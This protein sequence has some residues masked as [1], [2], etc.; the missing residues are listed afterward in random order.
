MVVAIR[1]YALCLKAQR[2]ILQ[3]LPQQQRYT[4]SPDFSLMQG[5]SSPPKGPPP[6][7]CSSNPS[8]YKLRLRIEVTFS[9]LSSWLD[10]E[11]LVILLCMCPP[12]IS[13]L[14]ESTH[15]TLIYLAPPALPMSLNLGLSHLLTL[16]YLLA[17]GNTD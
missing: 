1:L 10:T 17:A 16:H 13:A 15:Q 7:V 8:F 4:H 12:T 11:L 2:G 14:Q 9:G 5:I 6:L 3:P